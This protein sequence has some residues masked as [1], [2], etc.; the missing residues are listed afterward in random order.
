[1][2]PHVE[3]I[4]KNWLKDSFNSDPNVGPR[5]IETTE[6]VAKEEGGYRGRL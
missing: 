2:G 4:L 3:V 6:N 5:M 1:M